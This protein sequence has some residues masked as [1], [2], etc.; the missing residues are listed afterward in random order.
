MILS[1]KHVEQ[2]IDGDRTDRFIKEI[3]LARPKGPDGKRPDVPLAI[4]RKRSATRETKSGIVL[5][6]GYGWSYQ[7]VSELLGVS[8]STVQQHL[9]RGMR[10]LRED[11]GVDVVS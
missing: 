3:V 5:I 1:S 2:A 6:H 11:L 4:V 7:E 8:R 9:E 10:H